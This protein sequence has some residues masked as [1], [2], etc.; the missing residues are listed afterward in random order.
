MQYLKVL[1]LLHVGVHHKQDIICPITTQPNHLNPIPVLKT[2][3]I[4]L[5]LI[6]RFNHP[7]LHRDHPYH[8]ISGKEG[9]GGWKRG[10]KRDVKRDQ[11]AGPLY[12]IPHIRETCIP[13]F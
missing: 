7:S 5:I 6:R 4:K 1:I 13:L 10:T 3:I 12:I 9:K 8:I 2:T 11:G